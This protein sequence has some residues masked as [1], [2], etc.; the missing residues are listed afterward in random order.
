MTTVKTLFI[1][2]PISG[3]KDKSNLKGLIES[4]FY[5]DRFEISIVNSDY[6]GHANELATK[7]VSEQFD[8]VV[9]VGGDGTLNEVA[10]ALV[11]TSVKFGLLPFGSGNGLARH[12]KIPLNTKKALKMLKKMHSRPI[13]TGL[14]NGKAYFNMAGV[15]LDAKIA[16]VFSANKKRGF[17]TYIKLVLKELI[18]LKGTNYKISIDGVC[19]DESVFVISIANS[20]QYGNDMNIAADASVVDG[21]FDVC[22]ISEFPVW[23]ML[24]FGIAMKFKA[25]KSNKLKIIKGREILIEKNGEF[26][27]HIDGEPLLVEE[28]VKINVLPLSLNVIL[29]NIP[30]HEI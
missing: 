2:N 11:G 18:G 9:A 26:F 20:P 27:A 6:P 3:G 13:D 1:I 24:W 21:Y 28:R 5:G 10:S 25:L 12:L 22:L 29:P 14:L 23:M 15:G 8:L 30:R 7:A 16:H 17:K 19:Y 4:E